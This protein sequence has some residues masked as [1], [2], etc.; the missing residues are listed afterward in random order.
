MRNEIKFSQ[1]WNNKLSAKRFTSIR[2]KDDEKY[3]VGE[4]FAIVLNGKLL[5]YADIIAIEHKFLHQ[6]DDFEAGVD[7]GYSA[8]EFIAIFTTM[9]KNYNIDWD[10]RM[11]S[12]ILFKRLKNASD[13]AH[14]QEEATV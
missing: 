4:T 12:K 10:K 8:P 2:P 3:R 7:T 13:M 11:V 5:F 1:N 6:V 14:K 9:Y